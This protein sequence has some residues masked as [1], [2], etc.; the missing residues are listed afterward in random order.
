MKRV[1]RAIVIQIL[2]PTSVQVFTIK[3]LAGDVSGGYFTPNPRTDCL[4]KW[5]PMVEALPLCGD[6]Q[7]RLSQC[8]LAKIGA[9]AVVVCGPSE[10]C[11]K[12]D[13]GGPDA[14]LRG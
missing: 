6:P 2:A 4:S 12:Y 9:L 7:A 3:A 13:I 8:R 14:C 10:W 1:P 11:R 5:R